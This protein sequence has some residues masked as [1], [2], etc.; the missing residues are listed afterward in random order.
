MLRSNSSR[1]ESLHKCRGKRCG[2]TRVENSRSDAHCAC[3][4]RRDK[5]RLAG[6]SGG[7]EPGSTPPKHVDTALK[8]PHLSAAA[9]RAIARKSA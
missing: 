8:R 2:A 6:V 4:H 1:N 7:R 9:T 5:S 3:A